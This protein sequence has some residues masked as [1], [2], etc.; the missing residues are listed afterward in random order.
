MANLKG[1][2][3]EKQIKDIHH[4]LSSFGESRHGRSD[5]QTHSSALSDKRAEMSRSFADYCQRNE[6]AGK[7]NELMSN[8]N[9]KSFLDERCEDFAKSTAENYTR[10]FGSM[11]QGLEHSNVDIPYT[12]DVFEQKMEEI[13]DMPDPVQENGRA[14]EEVDKLIENLY[15]DRFSSGVIAEIQNEIGVRVSEAYEIAQNLEKHY[16]ESSGEIKDLV[17]KGNHIY[18]PK[19]ISSQLIEKIKSIDELPTMRTYQ[20]DLEK[21]DISSHDFRYTY[22]EREFE[23]KIA[24]GV[25]YRQALKE[26]SEELNH[27]REEMT[28]YYLAKA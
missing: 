22:A 13:R 2:S 7:L 5:N 17:G 26:I 27:S 18:E 1:G 3:F 21:H 28:N 10:A 23:Q 14:I 11:I 15:E 8:E 25:E 24:D 9:I 19:E 12:K 4:R 20:N 16:D 6:L